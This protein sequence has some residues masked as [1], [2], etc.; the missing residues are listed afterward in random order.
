MIM[1]NTAQ[2]NQL[3]GF[4]AAKQIALFIQE[5]CY[6]RAKMQIIAAQNFKV[7]CGY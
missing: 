2:K 6:K 1:I 7:E 3:E 5:G 4:K